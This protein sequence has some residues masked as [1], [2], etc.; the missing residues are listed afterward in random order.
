MQ[1]VST[2]TRFA[3]D[4]AAR[5]LKILVVED[6]ELARDIVSRWLDRRGYLDVRSATDGTTGLS[7]CF[8]QRPDILLLDERLPGLCGLAIAEHLRINFPREQRPWT[9]LFTAA[10]NTSVVRLMATGNFDDL[11]RKPCVGEDYV[12]MILRA[13]DGLRERRPSGELLEPTPP[14]REARADL[15]YSS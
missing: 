14:P 15:R 12:G 7:A 13:R 5:R 3:R 11:L 8:Q 1:N 4:H 2:H 9:V 10:C 6:D